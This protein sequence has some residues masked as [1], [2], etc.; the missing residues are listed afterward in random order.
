MQ[1][2]ITLIKTNVSYGLIILALHSQLVVADSSEKKAKNNLWQLWAKPR[3]CVTP[4]NELF[5]K[6]DT[7]FQWAGVEQADICLL[8]SQEDALLHCWPKAFGGQLLQE[9]IS[10]KEI[11]YWLARPNDNEVLVKTIV[12]IVTI[13]QRPVRKRRRH[14]WSLL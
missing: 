6:M 13:P 14:I 9:I 12:R 4:S 8:S 11:T 5:C 7:D 3:I 1:R 10:D 2:I